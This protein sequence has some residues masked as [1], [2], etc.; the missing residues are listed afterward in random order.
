MKMTNPLS[1]GWFCAFLL[2]SLH[3]QDGA[4][5]TSSALLSAQPAGVT[6]WWAL[7]SSAKIRPDQPPPTATS[8]AIQLSSA[9]NER[10]AVQLV[11]RSARP[12]E[13]CRLTCG[14]LTAASGAQI[15]ADQ[16]EVLQVRYLEITEPTDH[17]AQL[18]LWPDPLLPVS[19]PLE[20]KPDF[21][22]A[23]WLRVFVPPDAPAGAYRGSVELQA[24]GLQARVPIE[25]TVYDF[26]LPDRMTCTTAFGFSPGNVFRITV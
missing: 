14:G 7:S 17:A 18:G 15:A 9:R 25:L 23:F 16:V 12:I 13:D 22:H 3:A 20:L 4:H 2:A 19:G 1:V 21:N 26:A 8:A 11:I 5:I 24:K 6:L 10:E